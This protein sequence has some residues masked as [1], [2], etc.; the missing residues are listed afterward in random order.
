MGRKGQEIRS[1]FNSSVAYRRGLQHPQ[2][3]VRLLGFP[4]LRFPAT[5]CARVRTPRGYGNL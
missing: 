5:R 3:E 2:R 1:R 4:L